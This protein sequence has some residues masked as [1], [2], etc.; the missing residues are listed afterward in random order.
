MRIALYGTDEEKLEKHKQRLHKNIVGVDDAVEII[1]CQD[2]LELKDHLK[3]F[4]M[5]FMEETALDKFE[6]YLKNNPNRRKVSLSVG[7][8]VGTFF[9]DDIY[10]VEADLSR[11]RLV[12]KEGEFLL[13]ISISQVQEVLE[14]EGFV[15]VHRSY[16]VNSNQVVRL[17]HRI[18]FM[19]N[20]KEIPVSKYRLKEVKE[21][22]IASDVRL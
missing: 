21:R 18:A 10:Y 13:S 4:Q 7:K 12:T 14:K 3:D 22:L 11:I 6:Q 16:L 8:E 9:V 2:E 20:G 19:D 1:C 5:I 17:K 15:K